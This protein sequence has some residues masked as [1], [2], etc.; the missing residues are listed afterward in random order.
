M[1]KKGRQRAY[2]NEGWESMLVHLLAFC[3][4]EEPEEL[5][6][7]R[8]QVKKVRALLLFMQDGLGA[9]QLAPLQSIFKQA[10]KIRSAHIHLAFAE[11]YKVANAEFKKEQEKIVSRESKRLCAKLDA[12]V[13]SLKKLRKMLVTNFKDI[14]NKVI[15]RGCKKRIRKL[16]RFFAQ[17]DLPVGKLHLCRK[18]IKTLLYFCD[19]L[20]AS[21][22]EKLK[23]NIAYLDQLQ[24]V[25]GQWHD[26]VA[27]LALLKKQG[28]ANKKMLEKLER[29]SKKLLSSILDL[30]DDFKSTAALSPV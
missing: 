14:E 17:L 27:A 23:L 11:R 3:A 24:D 21:L 28:F 12:H 30:S 19:V 26:V 6:Q 25:I 13:K 5:H 7:F 9:K 2:F 29:R 1:L 8:I 4:T 18:K 16:S 20:P 10:G 22:T 15:V